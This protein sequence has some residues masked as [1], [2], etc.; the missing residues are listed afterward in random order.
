MY[1]NNILTYNLEDKNSLRDNLKT[2]IHENNI[3]DLR[4][5]IQNNQ[6]YLISNESKKNKKIYE[7]FNK[8]LNKG[9]NNVKK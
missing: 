2:L 8:I 1:G 4:K 9:K 7:I 3:K 6:D 5:R